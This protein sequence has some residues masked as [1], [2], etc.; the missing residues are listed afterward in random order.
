MN[1]FRI[2]SK[3]TVHCARSFSQS[4]A[5]NKTRWRSICVVCEERTTTVSQVY[6]IYIFISQ[7]SELC[8][9]IFH[10]KNM[11]ETI[12]SLSPSTLGEAAQ[13]YFPSSNEK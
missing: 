8:I 2:P 3:W 11:R 4:E 1:I 13:F 9:S 6:D 5:E 7:L 12:S 10:A